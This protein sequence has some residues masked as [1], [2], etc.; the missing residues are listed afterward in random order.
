MA[1]ME[2]G[3]YMLKPNVY[4]GEYPKEQVSGNWGKIGRWKKE[5]IKT[6]VPYE[7]EE[8][9]ITL[10]ENHALTEQE[11]LDLQQS[12]DVIGAILGAKPQVQINFEAVETRLGIAL[13]QEIKILY[14]M[15][16]RL[17]GMLEGTERFLTLE[18]LYIEEDNLIF[19]KVKRTPVAISLTEGYLMSYYKKE[20][21]YSPGDVSF[22]CY[23]L[24]RIVVK[25]ILDMP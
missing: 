22:L 6:D 10:Y 19:Y 4:Y 12:L 8:S 5:W 16:Y 1:T 7:G 24:S 15:L 21:F 25:A 20:W 2:K 18:E 14:R 9:I 11:L 17:E 3:F 13:P 23:V